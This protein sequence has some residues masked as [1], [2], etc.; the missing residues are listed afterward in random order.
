MDDAYKQA[1]IATTP[2]STN[3]TEQEI[4]VKSED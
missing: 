2:A 3:W 1:I 4:I